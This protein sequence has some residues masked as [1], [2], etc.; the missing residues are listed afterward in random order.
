MV[1]AVTLLNGL[2]ARQAAADP[3]RLLPQIDE[4][5]RH[6]RQV[7]PK[8][9]P[10]LRQKQVAAPDPVWPKPGRNRAVL[11]ASDLRAAGLTQAGDSPIFVGR[12]ID[13][14][15][16]PLSQVDVTVLDRAGLPEGWRDGVVMRLDTSVGVAAAATLS[17][18]YSGFRWAYGADWAAR[19]RLWQLP[20]CALITPEK[21]G[22]SAVSLDS[23]NDSAA[24]RV[25]AEVDVR[26][27]LLA[28]NR[29]RLAAEGEVSAS[30]GGTLVALTADSAGSSGDFG[31]TTLSP[32]A[33]WSTGGNSGDFSWTYGLRVPPGIAGPTP[34]MS[35][36]Y[37]S[38]SVD[39][40]SEVTNNQPSWLG[41]GFDY[42]PGYIER[43]YVS[44][45]EDMKDGGNNSLRTGDLCWRTDNAV[46][47]LNG[48]GDELI[49]E[50]AKGWHS[51]NEDASKIEKLTGTQNGDKGDPEDT[52]EY[53]R[54][55]TSDG[56]QY[57]FGLHSLPG[58]TTGTDSTWTVPVAGNHSKDPCWKSGGFL[59]SF[60]DQ[61]W[62][63]NLDYVV[64]ARGN[65][66][67]YWYAKET[68][69]YA[70]NNQNADTRSYDRGGHLTRIDYGTWDRGAADRSIAAKAQV[71]FDVGNRCVTTSCGTRDATNWPD[72]PWDQECTG[73]TCNGKYAPTFWTTKRLAKITTRVWDTTKSTPDWQPVDSWT[74]GHSF[75]PP[76]DGSDH[77][78]LWLDKIVHTGHVGGVR[79]MPPVTFTPVSLP[80]R[81]R[82]MN[83]TANNWQRIDYIITEAGA[84]IDLEWDTEECSASNV[85]AQEHENTMRC[86]PVKV[87]DPDDPRRER[88]KTEWWHKNR[89][90]SISESDLPTDPTGHQAPPVFTYFDYVGSPAWRYA[91]DDGL[92]KAEHK[93]WSQF[94]GWAQ[95]KT[96][97]GQAGA[98]QTLTV[99]SYM[100]GLNGDRLA[101]AGGTRNVTVPAS[102]GTETVYDED[103]FAGM[104][105]EEVVCNGV[106]SKP[107][108]KTVNVPWRSSATATRTISDV[109]V[110]ARFTKTR[111]S[112]TATALGVDGARGW[113]T[114][115][116]ESWF[117][118]TY[119]TLER[120]Q[121]DG[122]ITRSGDEKCTV[123]H[124]NRNI[125][126]NL[127]LLVKQTTT[128][129]LPCGTSPTRPEHV[130]SDTR[131][132]YDG[133]SSLDAAP[134]R[135]EPTR[136]DALNGWSS[137]DGTV[138]QTVGRM[139]YDEFGRVAS[140][141]DVRGNTTQTMYTPATGGLATAITTK[142]PEPYNWTTTNQLT[143]YWGTITKTTDQNNG[144]SETVYD[145]LG[146][147][148]REWK[149]GWSRAGHEATPSAE[150][151]Y[152]FA[153][154]RNSY[155][156]VVKK[157]LNAAGR[158]VTSYHIADSLLRP[159]Q[160]QTPGVGGDRVVTDTVYD[161]WGRVSATYQPH[162]EP[163]D[164]SGT[165]WWEPEWSVPAV[166][167]T[168]YDRAGRPTA[169]IFLSGYGEDNLV[170]RW[171]TTTAYEGD[172]VK[173]T[174][175]DGTAPTTTVSDALGRVAELRKHTT[176]AGVN[177]DYVSTWYTYDGKGQLTK[178]AD[179]DG[180]EWTYKYDVKGRQY[181]AV[182]PDRGKSTNGYNEY[183]ELVSTTDALG[184]KLWRGYDAL[185]RQTELR[186]GSET[187]RL[188][189]RWRYDS[190]YTG[191][192]VRAKGQLAEVFRY[193]YEPAGSTHIYRWQVGGFNERYQPTNVNF[194]IPAIEGTSLTGT[195]SY[196]YGYSPYDGT[197]SS[198]TYP[199]GG[200]LLAETVTTSFDEATGL[201]RD[202]K[203]TN[204]AGTYVAG[205]RYTVYG[206]PTVTT[207]KTAGGVYVEDSIYYDPHTRQV[208]QTAI[209]PETATGTV[210]DRN[211][212]Y[213][214]AGGITA[215]KDTPQIGQADQQCFRPDQLQ[216][217]AIA[218][219]PRADIDCETDP[220]AA[221]LGGPAPYWLQWEID[222]VGNRTKEISTSASGQV[223]T[224]AYTLPAGGAGVARP[225]AVTEVTTQV[226]GQSNT[227][228]NYAY[229]EAGN[230]I[231]RPAGTVTNS[232]PNGSGS[233]RL[234]WDPEGRL[235]SVTAAGNSVETNV[236]HADGT[237]WVRR[238]ATGTTLYLPGQEIRRD[239]DSAVTGTRYYSFAGQVCAMRT[240]TGLTWL[241]VDH[242]GTQHTA[243]GAASQA[244]TERRQLPYGG[245]RGTS[246]SSWLNEKGFV[247]GD[248]DPSGMVLI[249]ARHYDSA[250]G[251]FVSVDPLMNL[252]SPQSW[253]GYAYAHNG[254]V[255]LSD[256]S[257]L[258]VFEDP[259]GGGERFPTPK[260]GADEAKKERER[261]QDE[262]SRVRR[263]LDPDTGLVRPD[264]PPFAFY[265]TSYYCGYG[266][267]PG[268]CH[269]TSR[270]DEDIAR[271]FATYVC[272]YYED[273]A[274]EEAY[275]QDNAL[276]YHE[277]MSNVPVLGVPSSLFLANDAYQKGDY[278]GAALEVVGLLP[279]GRAGKHGR[280]LGCR[281]SFP[282]GT[283]VLMADGTTKAIEDVRVGDVVEATDPE[284]GESGPRTVTAEITDSGEKTLVKLVLDVGTATE[285]VT[286]TD[287]H[288]FWEDS[289]R[290]WTRAG[291]LRVGQL[292][293]TPDGSRV[294]VIDIVAYNLPAV[295]HNL[296]VDDL[297]TYYVLAG[298][299]PVLVHN[300]NGCWPGLDV[301]S[302][303]GARP[304]KGGLT[305]AGREYQKHMG[306]GELPKVPGK[307]LDTAGQGYLDD[308]LTTPGTRRVPINGGSFNGGNY[309]IRPDGAGAAFD[310]NGVFQYFG[311]FS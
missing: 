119:G 7:Q 81:V 164:P 209:R 108:S 79:A 166:A 85:P 257:G 163:G 92:V 111:V 241:Y 110:T 246:G 210:S 222:H 106:E 199:A 230:M 243:I 8:A 281:N 109:S 176:A 54:V 44:C 267:M 249:G 151:T 252:T 142:S 231:C 184:N 129:A 307:E 206:E 186:E 169:G 229:D 89:V 150:Y 299:V 292:V 145:P 29:G 63:W 66:V 95:V 128:T 37:S 232:C 121:N 12:P 39:G 102:L 220:S 19:L 296:T 76:G 103:Q 33:T 289:E 62:R 204:A 273:C 236:Y 69:R 214:H 250:L 57:Y 165:L 87:L 223:T 305:H 14:G 219:T 131:T 77:A 173:L 50:K 71:S 202:L 90:K 24:E 304:A 100:R 115:R 83:N 148:W 16:Q 11:A 288:P 84:R 126:K 291:D 213:N 146:R 32:S 185:G 72:T 94:R 18:D 235:A 6:G 263:Q 138:W 46:I 228:T 162:V 311:K 254:P 52:G 35:I 182:D 277:N 112:Y 208:T 135:G 41:E 239:N 244:V 266:F 73:S 53:W 45:S 188:Q 274:A 4:V 34:P 198:M 301:L 140:S 196:G 154:N 2:P 74:F 285:S 310:S 51:R 47:N 3:K 27:R 276:T 172:L 191:S 297:H 255:S 221:N 280:R 158:Y 240:S 264:P 275:R 216:R 20:E 248:N 168:I 60:C 136:T 152:E 251:R 141:T 137:S 155:P 1:M 143:P 67:S 174:P 256:P 68:N 127:L 118:D 201:P 30:L 161:E 283:L 107:V 64:D 192:T 171:R 59:D 278:L 180:N 261:R 5:D 200:G 286:A 265:V 197:A 309:Y 91:D 124:Y 203:T 308:I 36:D 114:T 181:E 269:I 247:G 156:H 157:V 175:P 194:V 259:D 279:A 48:K 271:A 123:H 262:Q 253:N 120:T 205:Q 268:G 113:R 295:V 215:I 159:R 147:V 218:W 226:A 183:D 237:R 287:N 122:D 260:D 258:Y 21:H 217:L 234:D 149:L 93:T 22:C 96:R 225:H 65:T 139:T 306:R 82:T 38:S 178:F 88:L 238:D 290:K 133:K 55:T 242:Q 227:V 117:S 233:Q 105:R 170:E 28:A 272:A 43:Q 144:I 245:P 224:R 160:T 23:A 26:P 294:R 98:G 78:G 134:D 130:V 42:W 58:H 293:R 10:Y 179:S 282:P 101:P 70:R 31:A 97:I 104:V 17:V 86:Y 9:W 190:L 270:S 284:T 49:F 298:N 212:T 80:N 13:A 187:G 177:G 40:R 15:N 300:T 116:S 189:A 167:R 99:T 75:P 195:W 125:T 153:T 61:A 25:S 207:R 193:R 211:F 302:A 132:Y 56:T 303:T